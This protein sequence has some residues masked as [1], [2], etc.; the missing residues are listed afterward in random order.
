MGMQ[1]RLVFVRALLHHPE[2]LFLDEPT[3]G[4]DPVNARRVKDIVREAREQ[5]RIIF[6]ITHDMATAEELCDRVAFVV[7]GRIAVLDTPTEHKISRSS[8]TVRVIYR[9]PHD[10]A[11]RC[12]T[13]TSSS[14]AAPTTTPSVR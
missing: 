13:R 10:P 6:L 4:M 14:T 9:D 3:S 11:P 1:M 5:G 12:S 8:R 2:L 7:D